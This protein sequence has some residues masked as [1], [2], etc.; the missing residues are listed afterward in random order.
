MKLVFI[1]ITVDLKQWM[2]QK[3][4]Q[5]N[6]QEFLQGSRN[7]ILLLY[8]ITAVATTLILVSAKAVPLKKYN[9][10][11]LDTLKKLGIFFKYSPKRTRRLER[12]IDEVNENRPEDKIQKKV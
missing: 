12:A 10:I 3:T 4:W 9:L 6:I 5:S 8:I 1:L 2:V 7:S 11:C